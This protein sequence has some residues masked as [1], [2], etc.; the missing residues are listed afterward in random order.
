GDIEQVADA[1]RQPLEEPHVRA[2]RRQLDVSE[3]LAA[4][5]AEG[6]FD[7]ALIADDS[8]ML[9]PLVFA[10]QALP[11]GDRAENLGAEQAVA[12]RFE[13]AVVDG[14]R[15]GY[16]AMRPGPDLFRTCQAD[17]DGIEI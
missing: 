14:F 6:D 7:A 17:P 4:H 10:A 16:F 12:F 13:G 1:A 9:H 5:L 11:I 15:L 2:G 3:T 8:A